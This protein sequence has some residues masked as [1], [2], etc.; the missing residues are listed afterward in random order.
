MHPSA[1]Y[2]FLR[3]DLGLLVFRGFGLNN[4]VSAQFFNREKDDEEI[5]SNATSQPRLEVLAV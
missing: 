1:E 5:V 3:G 2:G 4:V